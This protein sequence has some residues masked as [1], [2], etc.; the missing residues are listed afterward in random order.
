MARKRSSKYR[1][2]RRVNTS[3]DLALG[4]LG[5]AT[6]I[7]TGLTGAADTDYRVLS[8][9]GTFTVDGA[10]ALEGPWVV[11]W[12]HSDYSV[13]EIKE[14]LEASASISI[15]DKIANER[16]NRL[17]RKVGAFTVLSASESLNDGKPIKTRLNWAIN[18]AKEVNLFAYNDGNTT[19][20]SGAVV[21]FNGDLWV[22]DY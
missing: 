2:V 3:T 11:G 15:G 1:N 8:I 6:A 16:S 4:T 17:V 13:A 21:K 12:A 18:A 7:A 20:T 9:S 5:T 22:R 14:C 19:L 10:T